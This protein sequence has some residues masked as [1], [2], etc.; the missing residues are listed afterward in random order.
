MLRLIPWP[1]KK[2]LVGQLAQT[3]V[4]PQRLFAWEARAR[5]IDHLFWPA[6][7]SQQNALQRQAFYLFAEALERL[8]RRRR[9]LLWLRYLIPRNHSPKHGIT[10]SQQRELH[11]R[12][13]AFYNSL[14]ATVNAWMRFCLAYQKQFPKV[15]SKSV[16]QF[17]RSVSTAP[18]L[19]PLLAV[20]ERAMDYRALDTHA[21][22]FQAVRWKSLTLGGGPIQIQ[23][24]GEA[25]RNATIPAGS[26]AVDFADG[27]GWD[28]IAPFESDI[29]AVLEFLILDSVDRAT[30]TTGRTAYVVEQS[31]QPVDPAA[32]AE[33]LSPS[34]IGEGRVV[35][36]TLGLDLD[37][38]PTRW[39]STCLGRD[40]G[41]PV[42]ESH[43]TVL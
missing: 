27:P 20:L 16:L 42:H 17:L 1:I 21:G 8:D 40:I 36:G 33:D 22:Q 24:F 38:E 4:A 41:S 39:L 35:S 37:H 13:T 6:T 31:A 12:T 30:G 18:E 7:N 19:K 26:T 9:E 2:R 3:A 29:Y 14:H 34:A 25:S 32:P 23:L 43:G 10:P 15:R 28:F 5:S 11:N